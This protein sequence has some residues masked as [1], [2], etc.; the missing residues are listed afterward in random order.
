MKDGG[1]LAP[2]VAAQVVRHGQIL[3]AE[4]L[5]RLDGGYE[6]KRGVKMFS[7]LNSGKAGVATE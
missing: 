1:G 3:P 6:R 7:S 4:F 5:D 2:R